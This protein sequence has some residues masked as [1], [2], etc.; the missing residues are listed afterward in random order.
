MFLKV[1]REGYVDRGHPACCVRTLYV[2]ITTV[3]VRSRTD[4]VRKIL[5]LTPPMCV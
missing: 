1:S 2:R 5:S 3:S 4:L